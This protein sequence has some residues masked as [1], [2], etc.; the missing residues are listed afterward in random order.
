[1]EDSMIVI[2]HDDAIGYQ[3]HDLTLDD[4]AVAKIGFCYAIC[5]RANVTAAWAKCVLR[6]VSENKFEVWDGAGEKLVETYDYGVGADGAVLDD[7]V[8]SEWTLTLKF[9]SR[10]PLTPNEF[11]HDFVKSVFAKVVQR[12]SNGSDA[13]KAP[14]APQ[15]KPLL[16][17]GK[18][19]PPQQPGIGE[20]SAKPSVDL[21]TP[22]EGERCGIKNPATGTVKN[23]YIWAT[24]DDFVG[25][26][27]DDDKLPWQSLTMMQ[28]GTYHVAATRT[29]WEMSE[30]EGELPVEGIMMDKIVAGSKTKIPS[31]TLRGKCTTAAEETVGGWR[32]FL[33]YRP[34][35]RDS[36]FSEPPMP[37]GIKHGDQLMFTPPFVSINKGTNLA[38]CPL[39]PTAGA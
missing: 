10:S 16:E 28:Y 33:E 15:P 14:S 9:P 18:E 32:A 27:F 5:W 8:Q 35:R 23:G 31:S 26:V 25:V 3:R 6:R 13:D 17:T 34:A 39:V 19:S 7:S 22:K 11:V 36:N 29:E 38:P 20:L 24:K 30:G 4:L 1:M 21:T 37:F 12:C 2:S